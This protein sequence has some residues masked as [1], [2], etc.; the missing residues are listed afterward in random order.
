I[1]TTVPTQ[2]LALMNSPF[3]RQ[4]A[5]RLAQRVRPSPEIPLPGA[6]EQAY[7]VAFGRLPSDAE[8]NRMQTY[9]EQQSGSDP[10]AMKAA[11][12]EFCQVLLC[13]N[14]FVYVD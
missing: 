13:L 7:R 1:S 14:E 11:L 4:Q 5:E 12:V 10:G 8:R 3:V 2:A 6:I 9:I